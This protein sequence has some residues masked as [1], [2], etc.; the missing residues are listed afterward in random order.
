MASGITPRTASDAVMMT[1]VAITRGRRPHDSARNMAGMVPIMKNVP[2][3]SS[4]M[5]A[6]FP[7]PSP[8]APMICGPYV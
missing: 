7:S 8:K 5:R 1:N 4:P 6:V 3:T 2:M